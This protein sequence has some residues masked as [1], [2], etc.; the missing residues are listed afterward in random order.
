MEKG[1]FISYHTTTSGLYVFKIRAESGSYPL[2]IGKSD[3][4]VEKINF[5]VDWD[6]T[7]KIGPIGDTKTYNFTITP[8]GRVTIKHGEINLGNNFEVDSDGNL[9]A[10]SGTIG[11]WIINSD[12][13]KAADNGS[14][15]LKKDGTIKGSTTINNLARSFNLANG[16]LQV[17]AAD[18][19]DLR[20]GSSLYVAQN[21]FDGTSGTGNLGVE[22]TTWLRGDVYINTEKSGSSTGISGSTGKLVIRAAIDIDSKI[23][24]AQGNVRDPAEIYAGGFTNDTSGLMVKGYVSVDGI[25]VFGGQTYVKNPKYTEGGSE[26]QLLAAYSNNAITKFKVGTFKPVYL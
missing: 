24:I 9:R 16:Y 8:K 11:G 10:E 6:G 20:V 19:K 7:V 2:Q 15:I 23:T 26:S 21:S 18:F 14:L 1:S 12:H 22:G 17:S 25:S 4:D 5:K 3:S 13:I